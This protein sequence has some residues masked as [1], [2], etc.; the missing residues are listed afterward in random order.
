[1]KKKVNIV[2]MLVLISINVFTQPKKSSRRNI[3]GVIV[4][5]DMLKR[6]RYYYVPYGLKL[7]VNKEGKP[8]FKF[9]QMRYTGTKVTEDENSKRFRS[10]LSFRVANHIPSKSTINGI[11]LK[12]RGEGVTIQDL[13]PIAISNLDSELVYATNNEVKDTISKS[14]KNGFFENT[15]NN[16]RN[17]NWKERDFILR[18]DNEDAQLFRESLQNNRPTI[19][20]NYAFLAKFKS[21][22][23]DKIVATGS[24]E[25]VRK[26]EEGNKKND[27]SEDEL[28]EIEI[29]VGSLSIDI[30]TNKWPDL[31]KQID[32]NERVPAEYAALDV[33][34]YD[35]NNAIRD[36]LD[37]KRIE[38]KAI[39]INGKEIVFKNTF[40]RTQPDIY[41]KNIKFIYAVKLSKPYQYRVTEIFNDG[42]SMQTDW[43]T[44]KQWYGVLDITASQKT[45]NN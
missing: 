17:Q 41:A 22:D 3:D 45:E 24:E 26:F 9:I 23:F 32:L 21:D 12:L 4:Y 27:P 6:T 33:Y 16:N 28:I 31:I 38:I 8:H 11:I 14:F 7:V 40:T 37:S 42:T 19:S 15:E 39:S 13:Q 34:C 18:L 5:Q 29:N 43:L 35:F 20:L 25:F 44:K 30:N 2:L 10:L 1:M 36:D